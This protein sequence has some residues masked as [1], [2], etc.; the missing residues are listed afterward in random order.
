V[1]GGVWSIDVHCFGR[2]TGNREVSG[3]REVEAP[4]LNAVW[5]LGAL[6]CWT[7]ANYAWRSGSV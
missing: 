3:R 7:A 4:G 2:D 1:N 6:L 5:C